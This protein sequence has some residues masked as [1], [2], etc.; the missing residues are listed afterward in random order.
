MIL[1]HR[2]SDEAAL[3]IMRTGKFTSKESGAPVYFSSR[4]SGY[5]TD[6]GEVVVEVQVP[7]DL[8]VLE[9]EFDDGEQHFVVYADDLRREHI[10]GVVLSE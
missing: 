5:A 6:Y 1:Y 9:D 2:T 8:P 7:D 10:V 4:K 3:Q